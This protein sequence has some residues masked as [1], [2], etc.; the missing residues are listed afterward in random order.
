[1]CNI[2]AKQTKSA[3][4]I[5]NCIDNLKNLMALKM[6]QFDTLETSFWRHYDIIIWRHHVITIVRIL[7][8]H[9][10][11]IYM[12]YNILWHSKKIENI[13]QKNW[14]YSKFPVFC[15][16]GVFQQNPHNY[17]KKRWNSVKISMETW[18]RYKLKVTKS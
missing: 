17:I 13:Q 2:W 9:I 6:T 18:N 3:I 1:M 12:S 7:L 15:S 5:E 14:E 4:R 11:I 16:F 10:I 8:V